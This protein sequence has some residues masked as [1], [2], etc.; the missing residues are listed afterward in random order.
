V[1]E[2]YKAVIE[3][4]LPID[5]EARKYSVPASTLRDCVKDKVD[6]DNTIR[7]GQ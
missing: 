3:E 4:Y 1:N 2:V 6:I 5:R 7:S